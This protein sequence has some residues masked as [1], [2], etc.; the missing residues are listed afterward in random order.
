[1]KRTSDDDAFIA[2]FAPEL[3][4]KY[5]AAKSVGVTDQAFA[6]SIGVERPSLDRYLDGKSMPSVR[7][8]ALAYRNHQVGVPYAGVS[9]RKALSGKGRSSPRPA[10]DQM[11]LPFI[12]ETQKAGARMNLRIDPVSARRFAIRLTLDRAS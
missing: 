2:R 7:T 8:V 4:R 9:L 1:M 11:V 12:I 10:A 5:Q 6:E 3:R